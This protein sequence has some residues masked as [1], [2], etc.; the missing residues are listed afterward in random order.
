MM[1]YGRYLREQM[2]QM[3][4]SIVLKSLGKSS[5]LFESAFV[6]YMEHYASLPITSLVKVNS[7]RHLLK[8]VKAKEI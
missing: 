1:C 7:M 6:Q 4:Y 5:A 2:L 8:L 3:C